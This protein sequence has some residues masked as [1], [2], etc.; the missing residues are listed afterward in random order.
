MTQASNMPSSIPRRPF[1][2]QPKIQMGVGCLVIPLLLIVVAVGGF[3]YLRT[4]ATSRFIVPKGEVVKVRIQPR[5]NAALM[6][7]FG[8]GRALDITG[9]TDD[10]RW[11][12][13]RLWNDRHG[14]ARRPLSILVWQLDAKPTPRGEPSVMPAPKITPAP[15]AMVTIPATSFT[16]G[17]PMGRGEHDEQP[18]HVVHLSAF[19]ID[20]TEVTVARYWQCVEAESCKAPTHD[21]SPSDPII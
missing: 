18:A 16:M 11:L 1:L 2:P 12:Q 4:R 21:A 5:D 10:W 3:L 6:A 17:S 9:R 8:A 7:R 20:R 15:E 19:G 13:I 14:W